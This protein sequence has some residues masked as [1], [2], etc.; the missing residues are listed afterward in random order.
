MSA[1]L[2]ILALTAGDPGWRAIG[3]ADGVTSWVRD[4]PKDGF[5]RLR[6][7]VEIEAEL[8]DVLGVLHDVDRSCEW[9][10]ECREARL[11]RDLSDTSSLI[12][13]RT[14][15]PWPVADR[16]AVIETKVSIKPDGSGARA[17]FRAVDLPEHPPVEGV[18]RLQ[19]SEGAYSLSRISAQKTR[20]RYEVHSIPGGAVPSGLAKRALEHLPHDSLLALAKRAVLMRGRYEEFKK[21]YDPARKQ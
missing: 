21:R 8:F 14:I 10:P 3:R 18:V 20:V 1:W 11:I 5:P 6:G 15:C 4:D 13:L 17:E 16:D 12:Y 19:V 2:W 7:E 9:T